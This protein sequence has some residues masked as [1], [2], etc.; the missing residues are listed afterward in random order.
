MKKP[1]RLQLSRKKGFDLHTL[2]L[3]TNG[4]EVVNVSRPGKLGNPFI[5][6]KHGTRAECVDMH[7]KLLAGYLCLSV[8]EECIDAQ[9]AHHAFVNENR[10]RYRG[11]N[12]ACW[13]RGKPCH[14]DTLLEVFNRKVRK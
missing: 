13:C 8:D 1:T 3:A 14:G 5:V 10:E 12:V 11:M 7:Q 6:G 2:S 9:R 4:R